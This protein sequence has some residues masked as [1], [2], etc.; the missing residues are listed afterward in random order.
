[1]YEGKRG[2]RTMLVPVYKPGEGVIW[3][4]TVTWKCAFWFPKASE[5]EREAD[6]T[7]ITNRA[8]GGQQR[9]VHGVVL[10]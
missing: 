8:R 6:G 4:W 7:R 5:S 10:K 3:F 1:M 2:M 9:A